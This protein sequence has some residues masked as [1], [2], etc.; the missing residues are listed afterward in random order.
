[1]KRWHRSCSEKVTCE[2]ELCERPPAGNEC[3]EGTVGWNLLVLILV[4]IAYK[5]NSRRHHTTSVHPCMLPLSIYG[6]CVV[7]KIRSLSG[8]A[9][10]G[11]ICSFC[12]SA[13]TCSSERSPVEI[14]APADLSLFRTRSSFWQQPGQHARQHHGCH[15]VGGRPS[16]SPDPLE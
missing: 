3:R 9:K 10:H 14:W 11:V 12:R 2:P 8:S 1:M 4:E 16:L 13:Q 7:L 6:A 5:T 15:S